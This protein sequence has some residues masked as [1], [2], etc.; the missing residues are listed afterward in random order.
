MKPPVSPPPR[1]DWGIAGTFTS[2]SLHFRP[3]VDGEY[4]RNHGLRL[5]DRGI[6][7]AVTPWSAVFI[8]MPHSNFAYIII[9]SLI[10]RSKRIAKQS[11][12]KLQIIILFKVS[13]RLSRL[14][15][16]VVA[17]DFL[18]LVRKREHIFN[19]IV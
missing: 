6:S 2:Y 15:K 11:D 10:D 13:L 1:H 19:D 7:G 4:A 14:K 3:P 8:F 16:V 17:E 9:T 18:S 5:P 12:T